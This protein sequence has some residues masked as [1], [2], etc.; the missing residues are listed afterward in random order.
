MPA[1]MSKFGIQSVDG[2]SRTDPVVGRM[3]ISRQESYCNQ[4]PGGILSESV[5][6]VESH[7]DAEER[8]S[9]K[10]KR[11]TKEVVS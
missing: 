11:N 3:G 4:N 2:G 6:R 9:T 5:I 1:E 8:W 10:S 7:I